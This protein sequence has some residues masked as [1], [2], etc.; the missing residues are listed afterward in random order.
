M[1]I[2]Q[3]EDLGYNIGKV[4]PGEEKKSTKGGTR[5]VGNQAHFPPGG[6]KGL[7]GGSGRGETWWRHRGKVDRGKLEK[8][9]TDDAGGKKD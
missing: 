5:V 6:P 2:Y 1:G 4:A 3:K 9:K 8:E 7:R